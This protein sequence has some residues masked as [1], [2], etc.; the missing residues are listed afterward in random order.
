MARLSRIVISNQPLHIIHKG[1]N[2]Q[3]IFESEEDMVRIKGDYSVIFV[4][5]SLLF[6]CLYHHDKS[7]ASAYYPK[8]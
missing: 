6:S 8:E 1:N 3:N 4:E 7:P 5:D 2:R